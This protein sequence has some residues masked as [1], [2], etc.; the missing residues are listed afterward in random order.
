[1]K[2]GNAVHS[3]SRRKFLRWAL[4][5][6]LAT[7]AAAVGGVGYAYGIEPDWLAIEQV[8]VRVPGLLPTLNGLKIA[9]LSLFSAP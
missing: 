8:T 3:L 4:G 1:M 9:H 2:S 5:V 7:A 6:P